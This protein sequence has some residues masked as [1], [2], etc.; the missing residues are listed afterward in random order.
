MAET[1]KIE[2]VDAGGRPAAP[3]TGGGGAP[4]SVPAT[5][6]TTPRAGASQATPQ[7]GQLG[8]IVK[9][10]GGGQARQI[11]DLLG[12]ANPATGGN[13]APIVS[14]GGNVAT[15]A[16]EA[17]GL[18]GLASA[19]GP[20]GAIIATAQNAKEGL[21]KAASDPTD[22]TNVA[23]GLY[24]AGMGPIIG[25]IIGRGIDAIS[26]AGGDAIRL[27]GN[28]A[29][30]VGDIT[31]TAFSGN[32]ADAIRQVGKG[33]VDLGREIPL[34]GK[35]IGLLGD[36]ADKTVG[37]LGKVVNSI[38]GRAQELQRYDGR[39]AVAFAGADIRRMR[40]EAYEAQSLGGGMSRMVE[41]Q[42][43]IERSLNDGL[44]P[45]KQAVVE[46]LA[47]LMERLAAAVERYEPYLAS[48]PTRV[49][50]VPDLI[51]GFLKNG[52]LGLIDAGKD[53]PVRIAKA[54]ADEQAKK[55]AL[56]MP[57]DQLFG[58]I[59]ALIPQL[60]DRAVNPFDLPMPRGG[61]VQI[62]ILGQPGGQGN[63]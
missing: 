6:P 50:A 44:M 25:P 34:V 55:D 1:L 22:A 33:F 11:F 46:K 62:P 14:G 3:T 5:G 17:G 47:A 38:V 58:Q 26:K 12:K 43:R 63:N 56:K 60:A 45:L 7:A 32:N 19:A 15:M 28:T 41:A 48:I 61:G 40:G 49:E 20:I 37:A 4:T 30:R 29:E 57:I 2:I 8:D 23:S 39:L 42:S 16:G 35:G 9:Q 52:F 10:I 24:Q 18:S 27:V 53:L 59:Q 13:A 31:A 51:G 21:S 36:A 54:A